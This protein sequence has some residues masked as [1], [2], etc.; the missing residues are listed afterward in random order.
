MLDD[1]PAPMEV[2]D[3]R[4]DAGMLLEWD[5]LC[6]LDVPAWE[7]LVEPMEAEC[8]APC[9]LDDPAAEELSHADEVETATALELDGA[10]TPASSLLSGSGSLP[11]SQV[12]HPG[13]TR[14]SAKRVRNGRERIHT[15]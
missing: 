13:A 14:R 1:E 9:V 3:A 2:D 4:D 10:S 7:V 12:S 8:D 15:P 5:V 11:G 6:V